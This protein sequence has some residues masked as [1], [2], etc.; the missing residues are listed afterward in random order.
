M[1][2]K[3]ILI[4][5]SLLLIISLVVAVDLNNDVNSQILDENVGINNGVDVLIGV[6]VNVPVENVFVISDSALEARS[7]ISLLRTRIS[8]MKDEGFGLVRINDGFFIVRQEFEN[9]VEVEKKGVLAADY[10][11]VF[12]RI[13]L[14]NEIIELAYLT[15]DEIN[16]VKKATLELTDE[17]DVSGVDEIIVLAEVE[18]VDERYER[19]G[20]YV[21]KAYDKMIELQSI[22]AKAEVV[23]LAARQNI[24][25][26]LREN[27]E[28]LLGS[29]IAIFV[30][31][32]LFGRRLKR[33]FLKRKIKA[34]Y[35]EIEVLKGE[36]RLSQEVYFIKGQMSESEYHIKIK[37]YSEKIR[38]LNKDTAMLSEKIEGTKKR[39]KIKKELLENGTK[40]KKKG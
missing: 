31:F 32:F 8:L 22:E 15:K 39:N 38:T 34:N 27:W 13:D 7:A 5:I 26:F 12:E 36:I 28:V 1:V 20:E 40:E 3:K 19:A 23:Y 30:F 35:A 25:T 2:Y 24:E 16:A 9:E 33:S 11:I 17:I 29:V 4:L 21:E 37:I 14:V 18:F 6:D 10:S